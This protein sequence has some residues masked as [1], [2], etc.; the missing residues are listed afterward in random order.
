MERAAKA[1]EYDPHPLDASLALLRL[2]A[3]HSCHHP[4]AR[5]LLHDLSLH[6]PLLL[7]SLL[8]DPHIPSWLLLVLSQSTRPH[9]AI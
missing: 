9:D 8:A 1:L 7:P 6:H 2:L 4:I 3:P 5:S